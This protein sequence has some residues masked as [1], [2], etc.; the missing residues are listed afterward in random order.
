M[1]PYLEKY[2]NSK[3]VVMAI[4]KGGVPMGSLIA[5]HFHFPLELLM[6]KKIGHPINK[7]FAIGSVSLESRITDPKIFVGIEYLINETNRIRKNLQDT[8]ARFMGK[9]RAIS[10][11][12]KTVILVDD[13]VATGYTLEAAVDLVRKKNPKW[14]V[15]AIPVAP[16]DV[17]QKLKQKV[18]EFICLRTPCDFQS[19]S[20]YYWD[21]SAVKDEEIGKWI[22]AASAKKSKL[23]KL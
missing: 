22:S 16:P 8:Y 9:T 17:A 4:P 13:G 21:F 15:A 23:I 19:V 6:T 20:Q 1:I 7:E 10:L 18:D 2:K 12:N 14:I 11:K 3:C 5:Q